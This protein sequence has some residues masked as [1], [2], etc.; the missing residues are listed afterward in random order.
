MQPAIDLEHFKTQGWTRVP[1]LIPHDLCDQVTAAMENGRGV[2]VND[3][4]RWDEHGGYLRDFIPMWGHQSQWDIRQYPPLYEVFV[5]LHG[6]EQLWTVPDSCRFSPPWKPGYAEPFPL[7]WDGDPA[8]ASMRMIQGLVALTDTSE[9]QGGFR[10]APA[11]FRDSSRWPQ[12]PTL[13][14]QGDEEWL[15]DPKPSE[16]THVALNKGDLLVWTYRLP[17]GNSLNLSDRPRLAFYVALHPSMDEA[18]MKA[19]IE[20][21]QTGQCVPWWRHRHGYDRVEPWPS[22]DLTA[23][24]RK[25]LGLDSW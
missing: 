5:A 10:C 7:H 23:L 13:D 3:P 14:A 11:L 24:G 2:P 19:N 16:I 25:L 17:H 4:S 15:A 12:Q 1:G 18:T 9:N 6:Q 20:C 22:A 21:W 8:D